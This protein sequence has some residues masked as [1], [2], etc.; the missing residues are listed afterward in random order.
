MGTPCQKLGHR[1]SKDLVRELLDHQI[2][3]GNK[4]GC[5]ETE[6]G[7]KQIDSIHSKRKF[8][9]E[10]GKIGLTERGPVANDEGAVAFM[11]IFKFPKPANT[12][13]P[14]RM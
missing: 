2:V 1:Q 11:N 4:I 5:R 6:L 14:P 3:D 9:L 13:A 8:I 10:L 12:F 7:E